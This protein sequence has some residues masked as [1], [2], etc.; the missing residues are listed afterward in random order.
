MAVQST[1]GHASYHLPHYSSTENDCCYM[2]HWLT[3]EGAVCRQKQPTQGLQPSK[4]SAQP[5]TP[6]AKKSQVHAHQSQHTWTQTM[7]VENE[8]QELGSRN[9]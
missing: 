9:N 8:E 3:K 5:A 2:T 6:K 4:D 7:T 1:P